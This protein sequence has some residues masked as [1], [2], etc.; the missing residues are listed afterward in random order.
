MIDFITRLSILTNYKDESYNFILVI[1]DRLIKIV[2][3][4]L[5]KIIINSSRLAKVIFDIVV[6]YYGFFNLIVTD[7]SLFFTF[8]F[9][10]LL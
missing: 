1:I 5:I 7:K 2:Y 9:W 8:K 4:K 6:H 3:Y 10:L